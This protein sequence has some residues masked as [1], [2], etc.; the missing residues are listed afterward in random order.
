[1]KVTYKPEDGEARVWQFLPA[2]VRQSRATLIEKVY[3]KP[4]DQ[5]VAEVQMGSITARR[6]LLWHV[7]STDHPTMR[8]EDTP[9]FFAGEV[10]VEHDA[11]ELRAMLAEA[12]AKAAQIPADQREVALAMLRGQLAEAEAGEVLD[13]EV[14]GGKASSK[15]GG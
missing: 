4:W 10:L 8:I 2:R 14:A 3:G 15:T 5:F 1:M 9:D 6:V 7:M 11:T 12:E 13:G